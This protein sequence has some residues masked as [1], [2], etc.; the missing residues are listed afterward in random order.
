MEFAATFG[1]LG[2]IIA[3]CQLTIQLSRALGIGTAQASA[4]AKEYQELHKELDIFTAIL[5]NVVATYEHYSSPS[6][7]D[8]D[9]LLHTVV[10]ECHDLI[11]SSLNRLVPKYRDS[12]K[13][14][15]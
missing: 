1:S 9:G 3:V 15:G 4:S 8:F 14:E 11:Q 2:D 6:L 7:D 13:P 12:L 10:Q 5:V